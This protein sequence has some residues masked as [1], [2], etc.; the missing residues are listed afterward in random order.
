MNPNNIA[1][2][3]YKLTAE[4]RFRLIL[5]AGGRGD[6]VEQG[7]LVE[8]SGRI[9]LSTQDHV[10][11][12]DAFQEL[13]HRLYLELLELTHRYVD[14]FH[15]AGG[16]RDAD[17][18]KDQDDDSEGASGADTG[19]EETGIDQSIEEQ[20]W[21]VALA[22]GYVLR[23][24]AEGWKLFCDRLSVPPF[25]LW[26]D[27]PG[28][29]RLQCALALAEKVAYVPEGFLRWMNRNRPAGEPELADVPVT[30]VGVADAIEA[31]FRERVEWH[32]GR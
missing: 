14:S 25:V 11:Y 4:E 28:F 8:A 21:D 6:A 31:V 5:S 23:A 26:K 9:T 3:Y 29:S 20:C 15:R 2:R 7:R 30:A 27:L 24:N 17:G 1:K 19:V 18:E 12:A 10:P 22:A 32:G 16:V 13:A